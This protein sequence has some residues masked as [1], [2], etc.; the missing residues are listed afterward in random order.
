[1]DKRIYDP[2]IARALVDNYLAHRLNGVN[3]ISWDYKGTV[4][5]AITD[6][7]FLGVEHG[8]PR[9]GRACR[10]HDISLCFATAGPGREAQRG[11]NAVLASDY[12][13][14]RVRGKTFDY[15]GDE[16]L[17]AKMYID[18]IIADDAPKVFG[19][20]GNGGVFAFFDREGLLVNGGRNEKKGAYCEIYLFDHSHIT[21]KNKLENKAR[22]DPFLSNF[23]KYQTAYPSGYLVL[24]LPEE[25]EKDID[26]ISAAFV[27][28]I[29][30]NGLEENFKVRVKPQNRRIYIEPR[31]LYN[32]KEM[33]KRSGLEFAGEIVPGHRLGKHIHCADNILSGGEAC[34]IEGAELGVGV[35]KD[36]KDYS[37]DSK[38]EPHILYVRTT[39][40]G[41][42]TIADAIGHVDL[43]D[44]ID[45]G[46]KGE[47]DLVLQLAAMEVL[48]KSGYGR[49]QMVPRNLV[50]GA[51]LLGQQGFGK[52]IT[53]KR[54]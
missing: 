52:G 49:T 50:R 1:M 53:E 15:G 36:V 2:E 28:L 24:T 40:L 3:T 45:S 41:I 7:F 48:K 38:H 26:E 20:F 16:P 17:T 22:E 34:M 33:T 18:D 46:A 47:G 13:F 14:S 32:G 30:Y 35:T 29:K 12:R 8:L 37:I 42:D 43:V 21:N 4:V 19:V 11:F 39:A 31:F 10:D 51:L 44:V 23:M 9:L 6:E 27:R 25:H 54:D 5:D